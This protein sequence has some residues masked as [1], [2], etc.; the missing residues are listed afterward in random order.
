MEPGK[1]R[2]K[3][4]TWKADDLRRHLWVAHSG[5]PKEDKKHREKLPP[6]ESEMDVPEY[7]EHRHREPDGDTKYR[8]R[9]AERDGHPSREPARG[10]RD[11]EKPRE[12]RKDARD[13]DR[14][15]LKEK[16]R[17][18][19]A[20]KA[21]RRGKDREKDQDR[22]ARREE[23]RQ[24][25]AYHNL[26]GRDVRGWQVLERA[27]RKVPA[28]SKVRIEEKERRDEDSERGDEERERRYRERK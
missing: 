26:L 14:G 27:E 25:A 23:L 16:H 10:E 1:R 19:D 6:K 21:H 3:D 15:K 5:S 12:R 2:S 24:A 17:E 9:T 18:Q 20:E 4:D 22:R 7:K 13:Q 8:E 28:V 11:R